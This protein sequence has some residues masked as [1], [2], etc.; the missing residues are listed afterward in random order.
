MNLVKQIIHMKGG[1]LRNNGPDDSR[2]RARIQRSHS[3]EGSYKGL[4]Q[5]S[6]E[7]R[8]S[9]AGRISPDD[10][11]LIYSRRSKSRGNSPLR[12]NSPK[13][14]SKPSHHIPPDPVNLANTVEGPY[15]RMM[16]RPPLVEMID[17][18]IPVPFEEPMRIH[19]KIATDQ[20]KD[21]FF[22]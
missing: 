9:Q 19:N 11:L 10:P 15:Q 2:E 14:P 6:N 20:L 17:G 21:H 4:R 8:S 5:R 3:R 18:P 22:R 13:R 7:R 16:P 12:S 1:I